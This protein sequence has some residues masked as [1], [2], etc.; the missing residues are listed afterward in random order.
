MNAHC[1]SVKCTLAM[2]PCEGICSAFRSRLEIIELL[3]VISTAANTH[4][5]NN[6]LAVRL[7]SM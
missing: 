3:H 7:S 1:L 4:H 5:A 2:R 6:D